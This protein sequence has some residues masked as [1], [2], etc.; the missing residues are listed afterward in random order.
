[1]KEVF[2]DFSSTIAEEYFATTGKA[3]VTIDELQEYIDEKTR[4]QYELLHKE[5]LEDME[6]R[7]KDITELIQDHVSVIATLSQVGLITRPMRAE[8]TS[9]RKEM[10]FRTVNGYKQYNDGSGWKWTHRKAAENKLGGKIFPNHEVHHIN[11]DK[12]NNRHENLT[13]LPRDEHREIHKKK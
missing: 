9:N 4:L 2:P 10:K 11:G 12:T 3:E 1:M 6:K 7:H 8:P 13:V 5:Y